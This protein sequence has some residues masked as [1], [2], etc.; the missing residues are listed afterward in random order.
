MIYYCSLKQ[1]NGSSKCSPIY[2]YNSLFREKIQM[3]AHVS[4]KLLNAG[5]CDK[6]LTMLY[7]RLMHSITRS[8]HVRLCLSYATKRA[9]A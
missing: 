6:Y 8:I 9:S 5:R 1:R 7:L 2:M 4:L 3:S